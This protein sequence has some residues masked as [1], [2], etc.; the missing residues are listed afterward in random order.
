MVQNNGNGDTN[1]K[2]ANN[3]NTGRARNGKFAK[4]NKIA[5]GR[6]RKGEALSEI[7][8]E[9]LS[10]IPAGERAPYRRLVAQRLFSNAL[11]PDVDAS[12]RAIRELRQATEGDRLAL[13]QDQPFEADFATERETSIS[14]LAARSTNDSDG[15]GKNGGCS[16]GS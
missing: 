8:R 10:E 11:D 15:A 6:P 16:D 14:T 7:L 2:T 3:G 12:T 5:T 1:G 4:G 13:S 9:M